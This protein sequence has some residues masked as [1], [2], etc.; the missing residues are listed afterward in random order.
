MNNVLKFSVNN[1]ELVDKI[2]KS[3]FRKVK[4]K[5]FAT[6]ENA[7]TL[8]IEEDV[9]RRGAKTISFIPSIVGATWPLSTPIS[10]A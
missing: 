2:E 4:I 10:S 5:A 1:I 8:P 6:G 7:H 3:L 9:L